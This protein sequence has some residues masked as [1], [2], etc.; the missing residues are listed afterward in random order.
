MSQ[1]GLQNQ[2]Y[3]RS[4]PNF[5]LSLRLSSGVDLAIEKALAQRKREKMQNL[6][7]IGKPKGSSSCCF[8]EQLTSDR[9]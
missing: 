1:R 4:L 5:S 8:T 3:K 7:N 2:R 9:F 6:H